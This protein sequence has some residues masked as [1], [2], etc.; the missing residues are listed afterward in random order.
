MPFINVKMSKEL[1]ADKIEAV[2]TE[3]GKAISLIP[4][5]SE[6]WLMVNI[7]DNCNIYFKGTDS[8]NTAFVDVSIFG[9]ASKDNCEKLTGKICEILS[10]IAGIPSDR[11]YVKFEFSDLWGY[12]GYMF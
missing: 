2:K 4:G 8:G 3:L 11:A 7:S 6:A 1:T 9:S 12:N 10:D 5:K